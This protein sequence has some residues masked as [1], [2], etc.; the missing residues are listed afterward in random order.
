MYRVDISIYIE[1]NEIKII[2]EAEK[3]GFIK[4][5]LICVENTDDFDGII[6]ATSRPETMF[7][8]EAIAD[9]DVLEAG[10]VCQTGD[11]QHIF[12][13]DGGFVIGVGEGRASVLQ[14]QFDNALRR[15][16][17]GFF[18]VAVASSGEAV[19]LA[20]EASQIAAVCAEGERPRT[21]QEARQGLL[22]NGVDGD[23]N[24]MSV[25]EASQ[26]AVAV[27]A[28]AAIARAALGDDASSGA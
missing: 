23:G 24:R 5:R 9:Q 11:V 28:Y 17:K 14:R 12:S 7:A 1:N 13:E 2:T 16:G 4:R 3:Y 27:P 8:D 25:G 18:S 10:V 19:V 26:F 21:W 20:E 15:D 22:L 6:V